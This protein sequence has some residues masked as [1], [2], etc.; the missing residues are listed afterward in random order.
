[1]KNLSERIEK[2]EA[3]VASNPV[4]V[5]IVRPGEAVA[6]AIVRLNLQGCESYVVIPEKITYEDDVRG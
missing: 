1:M 5:V 2:L 6:D 3:V 4:G